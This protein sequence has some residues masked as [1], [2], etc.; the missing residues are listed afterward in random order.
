M[1]NV[2][3]A[4]GTLIE[5]STAGLGACVSGLAMLLVGLVAAVVATHQGFPGHGHDSQAIGL[6]VALGGTGA[7]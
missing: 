5:A 3:L 4:S 6:S 1:S 2:S 7:G